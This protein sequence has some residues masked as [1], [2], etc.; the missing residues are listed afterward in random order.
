MVQ[1]V[2]DVLISDFSCLCVCIMW[3]LR[4]SQTEIKS[5]KRSK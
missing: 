2:K 5:V 4:K 1:T 3:I